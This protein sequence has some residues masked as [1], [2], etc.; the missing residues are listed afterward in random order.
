MV[1]ILRFLRHLSKR[2]MTPR[3]YCKNAFLGGSDGVVVFCDFLL[4]EHFM[5]F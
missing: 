4:G 2:S 5:M 1:E 3:T